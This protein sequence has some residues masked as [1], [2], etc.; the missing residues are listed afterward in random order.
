MPGPKGTGKIGLRAT[1]ETLNYYVIICII[2][3]HDFCMF[4]YSKL[5]TKDFC[6]GSQPDLRSFSK[7]GSLG[8]EGGRDPSRTSVQVCAIGRRPSLPT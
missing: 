8:E 1:V 2:W 3:Q 5:N 6:S 4:L 7:D